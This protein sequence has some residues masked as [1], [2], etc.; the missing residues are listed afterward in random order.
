MDSDKKHATLTPSD[1]KSSLSSGF[2]NT[3]GS[4][5]GTSSDL[6]A[7][8]AIF[9]LYAEMECENGTPI[10]LANKDERKF[11]YQQSK[12]P[13]GLTHEQRR[14]V[15]LHTTG[16]QMMLESSLRHPGQDY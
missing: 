5:Y 7:S 9:S 3:N 2:T 11:Y 10:G 16:A 12:K 4:F 15:W 8:D 13:N 14:F 1:D 6:A